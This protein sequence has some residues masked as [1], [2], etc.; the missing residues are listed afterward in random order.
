MQHLKW[1]WQSASGERWK[2]IVAYSLYAVLPLMFLINPK[3]SSELIDRGIEGGETNLI[4]PLALAMVGVVFVRMLLTYTSNVMSDWGSQGIIFRIRTGLY[5]EM[6]RKDMRF[7]DQNRTGDLMTAMS[8]DMEI[9]RHNI[10]YIWRRLVFCPMLFLMAIVYYFTVDWIYAV[11]MLA[12]SPLIVIV[13]RLYTRRVGPLYRELRE[14]LSKLST[15]AQENIDGN[16]VVKAFANEA[17]EIDRF[18]DRNKYYLQQNLQV[19]IAWLKVYPVVEILGQALTIISLLTG[20]LLMIDGRMTLGQY[21]ACN[22][23]VWAVSNPLREIGTLLNS[24]QQFFASADRLMAIQNF[25]IRIHNPEEPYIPETHSEGNIDLINVTLKYDKTVV[26]DDVSLSIKAGQTIAIMGE[27]GSGKTTITNLI[28]RF[29]DPSKGCV[30]VDGVNVKDWDLQT[31]RHQIGMATQDVF[32]FSD[33]IDGNIAYGDPEMPEEQVYEFARKAAADDFIRKMPQGYE[34]I[35][36]ERGVGLSGGQKQRIALARALALRP[37]ILILDDTTSAVDMETEKYIQH[38][39]QNLDFKCTKIIIAQRISS[40]RH[41]DQIVVL[42]NGKIV[43][44][45]THQELLA[46]KGFYAEINAI[47]RGSVEGVTCG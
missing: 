15:T 47:Q 10:C 14:R 21:W 9:V 36:G 32:L 46:K 23:L 5:Q 11:S 17:Y 27:T 1:V 42:K 16:R 28:A 7:Y 41:A 20:G 13:L 30:M 24:V 31:L 22:S 26:L 6:Q 19:V 29:A 35:V 12:I 38:Q 33:T 40:V 34:T 37:S 4:V 25:P 3:I 43:E 45:G 2:L 44:Q 18:T 8:N 39:L